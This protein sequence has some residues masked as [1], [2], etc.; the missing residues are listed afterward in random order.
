M[1]AYYEAGSVGSPKREIL[2]A[3]GRRLVITNSPPAHLPSPILYPSPSTLRIPSPFSP[4]HAYRSLSNAAS[5]LA[6]LCAQARR[7]LAEKAAGKDDDVKR[8][9]TVAENGVEERMALGQRAH[10]SNAPCPSDACRC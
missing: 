7:M 4:S 2:W 5:Q 8:A 1:W 6:Q 3:E 9:H 10:C